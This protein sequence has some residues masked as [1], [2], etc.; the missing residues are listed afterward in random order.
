[1]VRSLGERMGKL[2]AEARNRLALRLAND[3]MIVDGVLD[4]DWDVDSSDRARWRH[5]QHP[6]P[7]RRGIG[8]ENGANN[9]REQEAGRQFDRE[10]V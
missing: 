1:M 9:G 10:C 4:D 7:A 8:I 5:S 6:H 3:A 2:G